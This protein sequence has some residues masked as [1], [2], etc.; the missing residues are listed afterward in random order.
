MTPPEPELR[1]VTASLKP[2]SE[3]LAVPGDRRSEYDI[4]DTVR[5]SSADDVRTAVCQLFQQTY[6]GAATDVLWL[7]FHDFRRLFAGEYADYVGC[8]TVYHDT[9]HTLDVTLAMARLL[10]GYERSAAPEDRLGEE[11][12]TVGL[13][14]ALFH[15]AGYVRRRRESEPL[16]GAEFT[17]H[18]V[19]R[20]AAFLARYLP[21]VGLSAW[22][23]IASRVV[24]FTG[25]EVSLDAIE[26]DDPRD[27]VVGHL[28]G[29]ADLLAQMADRCY[30]EKCRDRLYAEFVLGGVATLPAAGPDQ[31]QR[32][33]RY[34]SGIDLLRQTPGFYLAG[35][36]ERLEKGFDRS[37]R[38][39][40]VIFE[41]RNPY[42]E[43]IRKNL[44]Y[45]DQVI[46]DNA[47]DT[48]RR[49]PPCFTVLEKP[50]ETVSGFVSRRLA[51]ED[52]TR[53]AG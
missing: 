37:Y 3:P 4:T 46:R 53:A 52:T 29:T 15:A 9:Q 42:L 48:L 47:W 40:E 13:I 45:L 17:R 7:A 18:H 38:Y 19:S 27:S 2:A 43:G 28:L 33:R 23:H 6:P 34:E 35:A 51:Q 49:E 11:R 26:L 12:A 5:V 20:S 24:H 41:G 14:T 21:Q 39:L 31:D 50:L 1:L 44:D 8:D 22:A 10:A 25:Y 16:N 30:L 36:Q 32:K